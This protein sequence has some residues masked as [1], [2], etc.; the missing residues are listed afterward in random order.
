MQLEHEFDF[1]GKLAPAL[2]VGAGPHGARLV[3]TV[4]GG[5]AKGERIHGEAV[6]AG[7]DW[8]LIGSDGW[9]RLDVR[10]QLRTPDG[11]ILYVSYVGLIEM[12]QKVQQALAAGE[13]GATEYSD[14]YFRTTP[15]IES[16]DPKYAWVNQTLFV[17]EG[18]LR[19]GPSVEYRVCRV[20]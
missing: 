4:T 5:E 7:A 13:R 12:N 6:G 19:P 1:T 14:Q 10:F 17:A 2:D 11:A 16:G 8:L 20:A 3:F 9:G 15:R 18:R